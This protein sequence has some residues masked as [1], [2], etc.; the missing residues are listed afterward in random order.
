LLQNKASYI[1]AVLQ[2]HKVDQKIILLYYRGHPAIVKE[3]NL[4]M[5]TERV[6]PTEIEGLQ[7]R[8]KAAET[9]AE[10]ATT[11]LKAANTSLA[12][13]EHVKRKN[14]NGNVSGEFLGPR[15][16]GRRTNNRPGEISEEEFT[17][18]ITGPR[19]LEDSFGNLLG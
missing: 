18:E 12:T 3:M 5:L 10:A 17:G 13:L 11:R 15:N 6:D 8:L 1:W 4:F 9:A 19:K 14:S 16:D 7:G 2:C